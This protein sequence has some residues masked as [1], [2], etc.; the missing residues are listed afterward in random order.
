MHTDTWMHV[1]A[2]PVNNPAVGVFTPYLEVANKLATSK[3]V[4][5]PNSSRLL[6]LKGVSPLKPLKIGHR[7]GAA[8]GL[9]APFLALEL[10]Y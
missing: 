2:R 8:F 1:H 4:L 9:G 10:D 5:T 6:T 7:N 3:L